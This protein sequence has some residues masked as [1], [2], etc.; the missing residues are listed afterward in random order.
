MVPNYPSPSSR[1]AL[2]GTLSTAML[3]T[4]LDV[5]YL[6]QSPLKEPLLPRILSLLDCGVDK[7]RPGHILIAV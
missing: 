6:M 7:D 5:L 1:I 4:A 3:P 2:F